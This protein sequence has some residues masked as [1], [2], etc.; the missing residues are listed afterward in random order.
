MRRLPWFVLAALGLALTACGDD[1]G[2]GD[3]DA[4]CEELEVLA[5][6]IADG[7]LASE[8]GLGDVTDTLNNLFEAADDGEQAD[9]VEE[10]GDEVSSAD[11]D[12]AE[13]TFE[14]IEDEL[15]DFADDC[16][17]DLEAPTTTTTTTTTE[18]PTTTQTTAATTTVPD[19]QPGAAVQVNAREPVPAGTAPQFLPLAQGCFDG[20]MDAC[21]ELFRT[22]PIASVEEA[23]GETCGGRLEEPRPNECQIHVTG[24]VA[25]PADVVD[26][27]TAQGCFAGDMLACDDLF[28]GAQQGS[29]DQIYGGLCGGRVEDT[30]AFCV[31]IFGEVA[32]L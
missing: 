20:D 17:V 25:V 7:D 8:D 18:A 1:G 27:A 12:D 3:Q 24:P 6:Q 23:Y 4:F 11:P 29:I 13:D 32:L 16:D 28:R 15:G 19:T 22:T 30:A 14:T 2:G 9:A 21:D 26:Q 31:D 5:D 10:V